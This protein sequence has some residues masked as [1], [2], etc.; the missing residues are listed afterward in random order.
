LVGRFEEAIGMS[1]DILPTA[2][3]EALFA[4]EL[5]RYSAPGLAQVDEAIAQALRRYG[6]ISG[7]VAYMAGEYGDHPEA[8]A[9]RMRWACDVVASVCGRR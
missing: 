7:C 1:V 4:S 5:S 2:Q 3:A 8:A 9:A 6:G